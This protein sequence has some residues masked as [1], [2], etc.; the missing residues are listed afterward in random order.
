[1]IEIRPVTPDETA[2]LVQAVN[3]GFGF[4]ADPR[5]T[6]SW[7]ELNELERTRCA[8]DGRELVGTL[9]AYSFELA[10]PGAT[11]PLAGT[12][13]VTVRATHRRRGVLRA[14][15]QAHFDDVRARGEPLAA[16]WASE[17]GIYGRFGYGCASELAAIEVERS[18]SAFARPPA[19]GG[20]L[21]LLE[22]EAAQSELA[23]LYERLW[24]GRPGCF[25]RPPR[26]WKG[27]H[28][29][30]PVALRGGASGLRRVIYERDGSAQG[31]LQYRTKMHND[32]HGLPRGELII[33]ELHGVDAGARA[34]LWRYALDVDLIDRVSWWNAPLDD[35][36]FWLL[37]DPRRA[38]RRIR[39]NLWLRPIDVARA[40]AGRCYARE[41]RLSLQVA[42]ALISDNTGSWLLE[43]GPAGAKCTRVAG[44]ADLE[45]D[46][47]ALG[48]IYLGGM[49]PSALA[50]AGLIR[51]ERDALARADSMF[52][53]HPLP[54]CPEIF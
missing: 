16:L 24:R 25:A 32:P 23:E 45:L 3:L 48:G 1:M 19:S 2:A 42:D 29:A 14:M 46:V 40:L 22:G 7:S 4:D 34:A 51:G 43:G 37:A 28:F 26:W 18:R 53:W 31:F 38:M 49:R 6:E 13:Q 33:F 27:R 11:L 8:F 10:V 39:D 50:H 20:R 5:R 41:G 12:T 15:I 9:G 30:D 54:W 21:R 44:P 47:E 36:L 17:A 52:A 35:P